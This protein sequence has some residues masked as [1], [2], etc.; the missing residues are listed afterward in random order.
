[1]HKE[2]PEKYLYK[3][4]STEHEK[5][6]SGASG[7]NFML[8]PVW[9]KRTKYIFKMGI[10]DYMTYIFSSLALLISVLSFF[11]LRFYIKKRT[12]IER[13]PEETKEAVKQIINE[14]DRITDRDSQLIEERIG[15]LK[16]ILEDADRRI[17][18]LA[19][20]VDQRGRRDAAYAE[21]G[22][23]V[24]N[25]PGRLPGSEEESAALGAAIKGKTGEKK[26]GRRLDTVGRKK[27]DKTHA[28]SKDPETNKERAVSMAQ[29]GLSPAQIAGKLEMSITEI[30]M[31]LFLQKQNGQEN[32]L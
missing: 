1:M 15:Q 30:E 31:A 22:R 21:I 25:A 9:K 28:P 5:D 7:M 20:E 18:V 4:N 29:A 10:A 14:I 13:I 16:L 19:R 23:K 26:T 8:C 11:Y 6:K 17:G 32:G 27:A 24:K 2:L 3:M 12:L